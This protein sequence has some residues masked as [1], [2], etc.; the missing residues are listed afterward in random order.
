MIEAVAGLTARIHGDFEY[1]PRSTTVT[2]PVSEVWGGHPTLN[3]S[4]NVEP[5]ESNCDE[6]AS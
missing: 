6:F 4:V 5:L 3:V 1:D 2:I